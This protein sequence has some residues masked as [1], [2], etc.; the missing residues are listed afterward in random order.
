MTLFPVVRDWIAEFLFANRYMVANDFGH[1]RLIAEVCEHLQ[2][3][4]ND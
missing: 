4:E 1:N 3:L 2:V